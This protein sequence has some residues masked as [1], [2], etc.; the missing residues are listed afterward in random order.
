MHCCLAGMVGSG[1]ADKYEKM[2]TAY[3]SVLD[4]AALRAPPFEEYRG[5]GSICGSLM[6]RWVQNWVQCRVCSLFVAHV[7]SLVPLVR[8][9][10]IC[11]V[12][13]RTC[14]CLRSIACSCLKGTKHFCLTLFR[15]G[16]VVHVVSM[17]MPLVGDATALCHT[18]IV[19]NR[20]RFKYQVR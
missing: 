19:S 17:A 1:D 15:K 2:R 18:G 13:F 8:T 10:T 4:D 6:C 5:I 20:M 3:N 7:W 12:V 16:C 9:E 11:F 14:T